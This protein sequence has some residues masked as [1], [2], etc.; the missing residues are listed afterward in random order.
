MTTKLLGTPESPALEDFEPEGP[1]LIGIFQ[2]ERKLV[3]D[4]PHWRCPTC[5]WTHEDNPPVYFDS[6]R[7]VMCRACVKATAK[8][9]RGVYHPGGGRIKPIA[10]SRRIK[11][12]HERP[13][14]PLSSESEQG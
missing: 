3:C 5:G 12:S 13:G 4:A 14:L 7:V 10:P 1:R 6:A 8:R 9:Q 2:I 11:S